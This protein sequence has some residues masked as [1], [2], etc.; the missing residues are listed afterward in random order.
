MSST[1]SSRPRHLSVRLWA[2]AA[3]V[4]GTA[5][6]SGCVVAPLEDGYNDYGYTST[7]VYTT[8]GHPPPPRVEYRYAAPSP[9]HIWIGGDWFWGGS[10]YDWR[11]GYWAPPGYRPVPRPPHPGYVPPPP[12]R[13]MPPMPSRP[14][15]RPDEHPRPPYWRPEGGQPPQVRPERPRPGADRPQILP[16]Y[17]SQPGMERPERPR[18]PHIRPDDAERPRPDM[19][20]DRPRPEARPAWRSDAEESRRPFPRRE[21]DRRDE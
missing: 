3:A 12:V 10:R 9:S 8:Y 19:R 13:P 18:P 16:S 4:A 14:S 17:P 5:L 15:I 1:V 20:P 11:P 2:A 6:L 7:T 21:R